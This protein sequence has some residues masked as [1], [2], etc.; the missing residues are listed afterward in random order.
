M[1]K[2][3]L[4]TAVYVVISMVLG[5]TWHMVVFK[6]VYD[7]L[8]I[9]NRQEPIIPLGLSSMLIQGA[10]LAY[11]Y[12]YLYR[13]GKPVIAGVRFGLIMGLFMFTTTTLAAGA[14]TVVTSM[15]TWLII[16]SAFHLVQFVASGAAIG[17]VFGSDVG[18]KTRQGAGSS[19]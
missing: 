3:L 10:I 11:L 17:M 9:Y 5:M 8:G 1:K 16:Q 6:G 19:Q 4:A 14:K 18:G 15:S 13:G 12:P 7:S 2:A